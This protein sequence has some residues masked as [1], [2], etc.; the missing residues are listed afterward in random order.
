MSLQNLKKE[1]KAEVDF[2]AYRW[3]KSPKNTLG[4]K[5]SCKVDIA[6]INGLD[7]VLSNYSK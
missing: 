7:R 5:V 2:L 6:I 1:Y 3:T 4:I